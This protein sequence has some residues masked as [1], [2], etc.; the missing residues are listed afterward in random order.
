MNI[1]TVITDAR[2]LISF[3]EEDYPN[4]CTYETII[5]MNVSA[6]SATENANNLNKIH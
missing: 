5:I 2:V 6:T 1:F 4:R 3:I